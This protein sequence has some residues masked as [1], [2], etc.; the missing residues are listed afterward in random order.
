MSPGVMLYMG[1]QPDDN[2]RISHRHTHHAF[3]VPMAA[4]QS[5]SQCGKPPGGVT[6]MPPLPVDHPPGNLDSKAADHP[7]LALSLP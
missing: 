7:M 2:K 1:P 6:T 3:F 5:E 4:Q